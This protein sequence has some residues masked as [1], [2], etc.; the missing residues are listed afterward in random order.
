MSPKV[1]GVP[2]DKRQKIPL[3]RGKVP[4]GT[5][6]YSRRLQGTVRRYYGVDI[7]VNIVVSGVVVIGIAWGG[8]DGT[9][10]NIAHLHQTSIYLA[11]QYSAL[12]IC[13]R[14][15]VYGIKSQFF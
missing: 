8:E 3:Y 9:F 5:E 13:L 10:F 7:V 1:L 4:C 2:Y 6:R 12:F 14:V 15:G 11:H